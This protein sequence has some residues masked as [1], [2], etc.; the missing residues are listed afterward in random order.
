MNTNLHALL[1]NLKD[2]GSQASKEVLELEQKSQTLEIEI[3]DLTN[4]LE[5]RQQ[6]LVAC[7]AFYNK[8]DY[9]TASNAIKV[10][11]EV[12][13]KTSESALTMADCD[14]RFREVEDALVKRVLQ[15]YE[16]ACTVSAKAKPAGEAQAKYNYN[17]NLEG[18]SDLTP[19]LGT[20]QLADQGVGLYLRY[21]KAAVV[22]AMSMSLQDEI[23]INIIAQ[24]AKIFNGSVTHLRHHLPMVAHALGGADGDV[25]LVQIVNVEVE[26]RAVALLRE[27]CSDKDLANLC[28][29][30]EDVSTQIE[31][32]FI[33]GDDYAGSFALFEHQSY[34]VGEDALALGGT[35]VLPTEGA[36]N[37]NVEHDDDAR[38]LDD[39]GFSSELGEVA[40]LDALLDELAL[41]LQYT[42]AYERFIRHAAEEVSRAR[43][44]RLELKKQDKHEK[45]TNTDEEVEV[46][47]EI[48][49]RYTELNKIVAEIGGSYSG[50]E[51]TL[52][53]GNMQRAFINGT[54]SDSRNYTE[55][56]SQSI[57]ASSVH[58]NVVG[59]KALQTSLVEETF[60]AA[61]R[62]T[63]R[64]FATGHT[65]TAC[66]AANFCADAI[67]RVLLEVLSK[68][69]EECASALKPGK[70][71]L[72]G[73][74]GLG[75]Q[76]F[77][78]LSTVG[79]KATKGG[80]NPEQ[81]RR[82]IEDGIARACAAFND[83]EIAVAYT[84]QLETQ[85]Q[86]EVDNG[87][88]AGDLTEQLEMCIKSLGSIADELDAASKQSIYVLSQ[89]ILPRVRAIVNDAVG[90]ENTGAAAM[91]GV[92]VGVM[93]TSN[94][95]SS[96][97]MNYDLDDEAYELSQAGDGYLARM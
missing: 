68:R 60:Y 82:Q 28:A 44:H 13:G 25:G 79:I 73:Q 47:V 26:K 17:Y 62:S 65:G 58:G 16:D 74:G 19:L 21:S 34:H 66:A 97:R 69:V 72:V 6:T 78:A 10:Y 92:T 43:A 81:T 32:R 56:A 94:V 11:R 45:K 53:M 29:R 46:E 87:F 61:Q 95:A 49:A 4:C 33:A 5:L 20:L 70:G 57:S 48:I 77:A 14:A 8:S 3:T 22:E 54:S 40:E 96:V 90:Q 9:A 36:K 23:N 91:G 7:E 55:L 52:M 42:E 1:N 86:N 59:S 37:K 85:F 80:E 84:R 27:F 63:L 30:G 89:Q 15:Q 51:R 39:C 67:G 35:R 41:V 71:L 93:S 76:A 64:A 31:D 38:L 50:L 24:L 12:R 2:S 18:L 75:K 88:P 83:M